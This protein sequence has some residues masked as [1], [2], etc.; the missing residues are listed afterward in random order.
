VWWLFANCGRS[1]LRWTFWSLCIAF[2]Y[3]IIYWSLGPAYFHVE[4]MPFAFTTVFY[5]SIVTFTTLGFGD[6]V[7]K[8]DIAAFF[9]TTE[10]VFGYIMLGGL[11]SIFAGK[12]SR[13][14]G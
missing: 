5:Y 6:I 8:N 2:L 9:V 7:P 13:R 10:V 11:I 1:L 4:H 3:S 14:S 12:L